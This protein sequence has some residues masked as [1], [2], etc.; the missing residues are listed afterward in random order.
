V[1]RIGTAIERAVLRIATSAD[2]ATN[3]A[4]PS[5]PF[6]GIARSTL[7]TVDEEA[8]LRNGS[9]RVPSMTA[10]PNVMVTSTTAAHRLRLA[11]WDA[12]HPSDRVF[13]NSAD[14]GGFQIPEISLAANEGADVPWLP[15]A[16]GTSRGSF[17]WRIDN[18]VV[19]L[20]EKGATPEAVA[21]A[22]TSASQA[23]A[24]PPIYYKL[25][26]RVHHA[27]APRILYME[28]M[29]Q[30][31]EANALIQLALDNNDMVRSRVS[32]GNESA[33]AWYRT[34]SQL[35]LSKPEH[36]H[37]P[38]NVALRSRAMALLGM[39]AHSWFEST[40]ILRYEPGQLY[41]THLDL[42]K[43]GAELDRGGQRL[44]SVIVWLN[45]VTSGGGTAFPAARPD[46][47]A[48]AP[49]PGDAFAFYNVD[50]AGRHD[51]SSYHRGDP[52]GEG[53]EKWVAVLWGHARP[54]G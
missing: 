49:R 39:R 18:P 22:L 23:Q 44:V 4:H 16:T 43:P 31:H 13:D 10:R 17:T 40:Q 5:P 45:N 29:I 48:M 15:S 24:E 21:A 26:W 38:V 30:A 32:V 36:V 3:D 6:L 19:P 28:N 9:V 7:G 35:F 46:P 1:D 20:A 54:W 51:Y 50:E 53:A 33:V 41:K 11:H 2:G 27:A 47:V 42:F 52:P 34:S 8:F 12:Q 37:H 25:G 14:L